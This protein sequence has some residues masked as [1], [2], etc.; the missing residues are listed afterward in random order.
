MQTGSLL[1]YQGSAAMEIGGRSSIAFSF[2]SNCQLSIL[3]KHEDMLCI[4]EQL[5]AAVEVLQG[6]LI[7]IELLGNSWN[8]IAIHGTAAPSRRL[9]AR[10]VPA[11]P[12][13]VTQIVKGQGRP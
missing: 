8:D 12:V 3:N 9:Y 11:G 4:R 7:L 5:S 2:C 13:I 6:R 1:V 10:R